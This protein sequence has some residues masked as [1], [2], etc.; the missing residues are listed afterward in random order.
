MKAATKVSACRIS[1]PPEDAVG[2]NTSWDQVLTLYKEG[3]W[4]ELSGSQVE[5]TREVLQSPRTYWFDVSKECIPKYGVRVRFDD[6][7]EALDIN[8]C[9]ECNMLAIVRDGK[10]VGS[11]DDFDGGAIKLTAI[12]KELFPDDPE[13]QALKP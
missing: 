11:E 12:C 13:I 7:G 5:Q 1:K 4:V 10:I 2:H 6:D 9:F 8:L 3:E